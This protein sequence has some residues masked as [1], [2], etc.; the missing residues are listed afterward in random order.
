MKARW[1]GIKGLDGSVYGPNNDR[2]VLVVKANYL[3]KTHF[4]HL[5]PF[6]KKTHRHGNEG[7]FNHRTTHRSTHCQKNR[8]HDVE[9]IIDETT[10][11]S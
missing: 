3:D 8:R 1:Y 10:S 7:N 4:T 9:I 2:F 5:C 11:R 6:C